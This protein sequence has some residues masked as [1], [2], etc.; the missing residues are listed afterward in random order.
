MTIYTLALI[1]LWAIA[2]ISMSRVKHAAG[3][4]AS[5]AWGLTLIGVMRP[6]LVEDS[7]FVFYITQAGAWA[8]FLGSLACLANYGQTAWKEWRK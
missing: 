2:F 4:L 8:V 7:R 6:D 1:A 3:M 5:W